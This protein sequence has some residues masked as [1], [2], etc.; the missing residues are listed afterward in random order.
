LDV[1]SEGRE[2]ERAV[3]VRR[4]EGIGVAEGVVSVSSGAPQSVD[5][6]GMG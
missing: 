2:V 5:E 1:L 3:V 4:E 6:G